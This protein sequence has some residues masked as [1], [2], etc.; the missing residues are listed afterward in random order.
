M[1]RKQIGGIEHRRSAIRKHT[2]LK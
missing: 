2:Q 1:E